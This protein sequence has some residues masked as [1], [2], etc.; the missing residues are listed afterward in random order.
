MITALAVLDDWFLPT[1]EPN[2]D[3]LVHDISDLLF[4]GLTGRPQR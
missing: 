2:R 3:Q 4:H 1:E